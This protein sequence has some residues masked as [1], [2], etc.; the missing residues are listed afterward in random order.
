VKFANDEKQMELVMPVFEFES[1]DDSIKIAVKTE[2]DYDGL[3]ILFLGIKQPN[4]EFKPVTNEIDVTSLAKVIR[5]S[6]ENFSELYYRFDFTPAES[7]SLA[8]FGYEKRLIPQKDVPKQFD[9][10]S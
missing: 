1:E 7:D 3:G 9:R 6:K 4:G 10:T 5:I 2:I 8:S